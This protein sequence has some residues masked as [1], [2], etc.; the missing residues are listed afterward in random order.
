MKACNSK[1]PKKPN[2]RTSGIFGSQN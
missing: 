2:K 1:F